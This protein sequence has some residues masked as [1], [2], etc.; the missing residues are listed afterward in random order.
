MYLIPACFLV[1]W[2]VK[3]KLLPR[4]ERIP[5]GDH[6]V[7]GYGMTTEEL[8][9]KILRELVAANPAYYHFQG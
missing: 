8:Y 1:A 2:Q 6:K 9:L 3:I 5:D 7:M 4:K